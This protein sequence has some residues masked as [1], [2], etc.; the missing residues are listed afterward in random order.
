[1][2]KRLSWV[3]VPLFC[4]AAFFLVSRFYRAQEEEVVM[5]P[6]HTWS[7]FHEYPRLEMLFKGFAIESM[8]DVPSVDILD[9]QKHDLGIT[10][11]L[12]VAESPIQARGLQAQ[13]G[14]AERTFSH[15]R[16]DVDVMPK[17]DLILCWDALCTLSQSEVKASLLQ[18]KKSGAKFLLMRHYH[19]I[20]HNVESTNGAFHPI[21]WNNPP[22]N[23]PEPIIHIME[24]G[25]NGLVSLALWSLEQL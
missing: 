19:H 18:F 16:I 2:K 20:E 22:Y 6:P 25:E 24:E 13:F 8:I 3:L 14:S 15:F 7:T 17:V 21:N 23:F 10:I 9:Y 4:V 1:M 5:Q 11:Y 12:G